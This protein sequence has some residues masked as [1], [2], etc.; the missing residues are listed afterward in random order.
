MTNARAGDRGALLVIDAQ[1]GVMNEAW[2]ADR[3][4][5]AAT[6]WCVRATAHAALER[7]YDV[8]LVADGRTTAGESA[9]TVVNDLNDVLRWVTYPDVTSSVAAVDELDFVAFA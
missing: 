1:V 5:R 7:G 2:A 4:G 3:P 9:E 6:N 8:V